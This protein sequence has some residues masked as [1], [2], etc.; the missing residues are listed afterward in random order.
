[1]GSVARNTVQN[2]KQVQPQ[3]L[4][5]WLPL[6]L[7]EILIAWRWELSQQSQQIK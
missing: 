4:C 6:A 7:K 2:N 1:M 5:K 3:W